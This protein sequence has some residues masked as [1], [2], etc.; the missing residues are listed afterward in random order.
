MTKEI[1]T[2]VNVRGFEMKS[3]ILSGEITSTT[4]VHIEVPAEK[5][6]ALGTV[7]NPGKDCFHFEVKLNFSPKSKEAKGR[8]RFEE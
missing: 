3:W 7:W 1:E 2:V 8:T 5:Q 4:D 6:K